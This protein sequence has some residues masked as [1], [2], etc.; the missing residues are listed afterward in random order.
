MADHRLEIILAAKDI[1]GAA[2]S[3]AQSNLNALKNTVFSL[4]GALAGLGLTYGLK[5]IA[6]SFLD[7]ARVTENYK[8]RLEVLLGSVKE[9]NRLFQ[10]M[11][12]YASR[13]PFEFE[14]IMGAATQLSGVMKGGVNEIKSWMPLIG[15]LAAVSGLSIQQTTEQVA[16]M[17]SAGA[18]SADLFR[19]RGIL[20]MLGFQAGVSYSVN[21]TRKIMVDSWNNTDSQ[22]RGATNKLSG[23]W[24]G[25]MS[26]MKDKWFQF[27]NI[28]MEAGVFDE[29]KKQ[30]GEINDKVAMWLK[31]NEALIKQKVPEYIKKVKE[32]AESFFNIVT[33]VPKE[34]YE[35]GLIAVLLFGKKGVLLFG[36]AAWLETQRQAVKKEIDFYQK[37]ID[38]NA[39]ISEAQQGMKN[40]VFK[41]IGPNPFK[42]KPVSDANAPPDQSFTPSSTGTPS[43]TGSS[44]NAADKEYIAA[45]N[46]WKKNLE[47]RVKFREEL[48][49]KLKKATLTEY[50]YEKWALER[51]VDD[52]RDRVGNDAVLYDQMIEYRKAKLAELGQEHIYKDREDLR[53]DLT[54]QI[55]QATL[56]EYEYEKWTLE[57]E[58]DAM[59]QR[60]GDDATL[61]DQMMEY[62]KVKLAE[63]EQEH[64]TSSTYMID[65]SKRTAEAM[66]QNFSDLFF[67][68]MT[69]KFNTLRDYTTAIMNS[70]KRALA[71]VLGQMA[72]AALI[73]GIGAAVSFFNPAAGAAVTIGAGTLSGA[74]PGGTPSAISPMA[75]GG[76][77]GASK[78][79]PFARGGV[80]SSP[81]VFPFA[82]GVGMMGEAGPEAIMPL[83]RNASGEL[84]VQADKQSSQPLEL[85]ILN[86]PDPSIVESFLSTSRGKNAF[87]NMI[88]MNASTIRRVLA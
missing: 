72:K 78:V 6:G 31:N 29:L 21:E 37:Y 32:T 25:Q 34:I 23:T 20:S 76:V 51:E 18:A 79:F 22:F 57:N 35:F 2:F 82:N 44:D 13:T 53:N 58:V 5:E 45:T 84:G 11:S 9:G 80:V 39:G 40:M 49:D 50:E 17:Y 66:E 65:L 26:M 55:K 88:T 74:M 43:L 87:I 42:D 47:D 81:A 68:V 77:F 62:R 19:E 1:S 38:K 69:G 41:R 36:A 12:A 67:D 27:R 15:D 75:K 4:K 83:K 30:L 85:T 71:D 73:K 7:A 3:R 8:V 54:N 63:I 52:M 60:V 14:E 56:T 46:A 70:I 86:V 48:T 16:R 33:G 24:D 28:V 59:R 64:N 10:E 61:Y